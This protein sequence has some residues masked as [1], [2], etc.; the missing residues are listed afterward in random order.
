MDCVDLSAKVVATARARLAD[1][2]NIA[3]H[4]ADM[5]ALP[6]PDGSFDHVLLLAGLSYS[7]RPARALAE[8]ARALTPG[9]RMVAPTLHRHPH[10]AEVARFDHANSGFAPDELHL[11]A[12]EAGFELVACGVTSRERRP[13]QF[14]VITLHARCPAQSRP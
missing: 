13:P 11:L 14:Q 12:E 1:V 9:G 10:S 6:F 7:D 8:A 2:P 3:V 4:Q 5:H